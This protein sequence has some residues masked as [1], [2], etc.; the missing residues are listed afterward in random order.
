MKRLFPA[1]LAAVCLSGCTVPDAGARGDVAQVKTALG[2]AVQAYGIAKGIAGVAVAS[3]PTL[4]V[5]VARIEAV[6][7]PLIPLANT[8]LAEADANIGQVTQLLREIQTEVIAMET[9]T[10]GQVKV[11]SNT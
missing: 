3:D 1:A 6:I 2:Q 7:D 10:A 11:V 9:A 5:P 8:V 4:A